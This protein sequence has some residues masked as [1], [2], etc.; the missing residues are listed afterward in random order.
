MS[1]F[2]GLLV[3]LSL[4]G[5]ASYAQATTSSVSG[6]VSDGQNEPLPGTTVMAIH[7]PS[8]TRYGTVTNMQGNYQLQGM[9]TG[10]PYRIEFSYVGYR[11]AIVTDI[12]L[13]LAEN[14]ACDSKLKESAELDEVVVLGTASKFAGEKT[15][16]STHIT[17]QDISY[18]PN[19]SRGLIAL[20]KMSPYSSRNGFGGRD[21][22]MNN[23]T[24]DGANFNFSMGLDGAVLPGGGNPISIDALEEVQVSIAPFDIRQSNFVGGSVNAVTK[25]GTNRYRGSAYMYVKNENLRGN[26]VDG[27]DLGK[28]EEER[29]SVY[30]FTFGGPI[31]K[32]KLFFFVNGEYEY[33][34]QP[35]HKWK[36]STDGKEDIQNLISRV[37]ADDMSRFSH[38]LKEMYGY[39]TGSWTDF[40][41]CTEVYRAM[42]RLDWNITDNHRFMLRYN[43]TGQKKDNNLVG[44]ALNIS[45]APVSRYSMSFR[46]STWKQ[47]DNV[48]SLTAELNSR[49]SST[50]NNQLL[51]SFTFNDGNK[52][53]CN[54]DFPT[55]DI[56]KPDETGTNRAFMNAGYE[57][58]AWKN[59]ITERVWSITDNLSIHVGNHNMTLGASFESQNVSN[60]YMRY[61]AGYYR[62]NSYEDFV[63]K[64]APVAF[65][66][67]YSLTGDDD[68][69]AS[70]HYDQFSLYAQDEF[71]ANDRLKLLYGIRMDIPFYVNK[72]YENPSISSYEFN[73]MKLSTAH[74]PKATPLFSPRIG[75]NYDLT[76]DQIMKLRGGTGVFTGRFPLIFL[77]KMQEG[78][79]MLRNIVS[80]QTV[81]DELL[82][83]LAGGIRTP[84]QILSEIAPQF[85]N[86]FP[87]EPGA[88]NEIVTIDRKFKT[89]QVWT[90]SLA[91]DYR[92]PL[93]FRSDLTLE[94][95]YVKDINAI[96]QRNVNMVDKDDPKM[97]HFSGADDR[98]IYP[99]SKK[100]DYLDN[101]VN[102]YITRAMLMTN[103]SKGYSYNLNATLNM[104]PVRNL[105]L[106]ASYTYTKSRSLSNNASNQIENAWQQEPSVQGANYLTMHNASYL[107]S[108]HRV[109]ASASYTIAYAKNFATSVS[110]FYTGQRNGSYSY[111]ID[112]DLNN[113]GSQFDLMYV[114]ATRDELNFADIKNTAGAVLFSADEQRDAFWAFVNQDPYLKKRKGKY[115]E[116]NGAFQPWYHRFDLRIVQDFKI[117]AGKST[118][119]LQLSMDM[120]NLGNLLNSAWGVSKAATAVKLL[121]CEMNGGQ[122]KLNDNNSPIYTMTTL[123][124]DGNTILPYRS[125]APTR[126]TSN[127]WQLQFGIRYIFN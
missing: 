104:E 127:C 67:S 13:K 72:R 125:F 95:I 9:R 96:L 15:G 53:E 123:T 109:I 120:M 41:G 23:Y 99:G 24:I 126:T 124:E 42:A 14:Y 84:Q 5:V 62:Y 101:R 58:H 94:A 39:D 11:R 103:T 37:T 85:P 80:T 18:F 89:P 102:R 32:N 47:L 19:I 71:N 87:M 2:W 17:S 34:P 92:L 86:R 100:D 78:S 83:A 45:G 79:G 69:L 38:D 40:A 7:E 119:T 111:M 70:V 21:Q 1:K 8:G 49:F 3:M 107:D 29:R 105:N 108:P 46:N 64:A 114:P 43:Y 50:V 30:G 16:A 12:Y 35:I 65:A 55:V 60:C 66:L 61:G 112:G 26:E 48:S 75:F 81:N 28:R 51:A 116:T 56:M 10:G 82:A 27:F 77:S 117:K 4:Y 98:Y 63:N 73:G 90:S 76:G 88:V 68:A 6:K 93:P 115:A 74:W 36:L 52:R 25:S 122:V 33:S 57:Q 91:L 110:L 54:G 20:T 22:R 113:D 106:M 97:S 118:N 31:V 59:G 44:A 121:K